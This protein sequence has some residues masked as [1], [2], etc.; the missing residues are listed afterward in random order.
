MIQVL[1]LLLV[2]LLSLLITRVATVALTLTG[3]SKQSAR[4]QARSALTGAGY[5]TTESEQIVNHPVR[6]RIV[7]WLMLLGNG[8]LVIVASLVILTFTSDNSVQWTDVVFLSLGAGVLWFLAVSQWVDKWLTR[9]IEYM[10]SHSTDIDIRD[11]AGLLRLRG[12]YKIVEMSIREADW[13]AERDLVQL[14]LSREGA[15]VLGINRQDGHFRGAPRAD[16]QLKPG[17]TV[18]LYGS[19]DSLAALD[20]RRRGA[21]GNRE[22]VQAVARQQEKSKQEQEADDAEAQTDQPTV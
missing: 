19:E 6:R 22:H 16:T 5:T 9:V 10:L 13:L 21:A 11:Y 14:G 7:M 17:D 1:S 12:E 18:L 2:L 15:L 4:F 8:G 20:Q 3:L